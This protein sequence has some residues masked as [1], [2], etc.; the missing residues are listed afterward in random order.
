[1]HQA[2]Y[3]AVKG[4]VH[5]A[6]DVAR[7]GTVHSMHQG[8]VWYAASTWSY[9]LELCELCMGPCSQLKLQLCMEMRV[10]LLQEL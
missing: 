4:T 10:E 1:M 3:A 8:T 9:V 6:M 5:C 2:L 7:K